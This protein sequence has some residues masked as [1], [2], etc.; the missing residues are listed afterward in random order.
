MKSFQDYKLW[1]FQAPAQSSDPLRANVGT[2]KVAILR[3]IETPTYVMKTQMR[4]EGNSCEE[5]ATWTPVTCT[6]DVPLKVL[7]LAW[8]WEKH[9]DPAKVGTII[10]ARVTFSS[11]NG[12]PRGG[13]EVPLKVTESVSPE[14]LEYRELGTDPVFNRK[15][16][17]DC[18]S[19]DWM[20]GSNSLMLYRWDREFNTQNP[21]TNVNE[22]RSE[23]VATEVILT[24]K[25]GKL[26][27]TDFAA[28][29][30]EGAIDET[31]FPAVPGEFATWVVKRSEGLGSKSCSIKWGVSRLAPGLIEFQNDQFLDKLNPQI[32]KIK[33]VTLER[34]KKLPFVP[35]EIADGIKE[36]LDQGSGKVELQ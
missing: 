21:E 20:K 8:F 5:G 30:G 25:N 17:L 2:D 23:M 15:S 33:D 34:L 31:V 35:A 13:Y 19:Y 28:M 36:S 22:N 7:A 4:M 10:Q 14:I 6:T 29:S 26:E 11:S 18:Q 12:R 16:F 1:T 24:L 3:E 32:H 9:P 27:L